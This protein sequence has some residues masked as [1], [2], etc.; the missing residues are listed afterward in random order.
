MPSRPV[1]A[2][3][4]FYLCMSFAGAAV[5]IGVILLLLFGCVGIQPP[6]SETPRNM[7]CMT[8]DQLERELAK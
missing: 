3:E 6:C 8:G 5:A 4:A 7:S 2:K 1:T